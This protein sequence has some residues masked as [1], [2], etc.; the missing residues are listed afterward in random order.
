MNFKTDYTR[1]KNFCIVPNLTLNRLSPLAVWP[2]RYM[3]SLK[4]YKIRKKII[5]SKLT[6]TA[7]SNEVSC[8]DNNCVS[9][10][11]RFGFPCQE[12]KNKSV[13]KW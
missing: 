11:M 2:C 8:H 5:Y 6:V 10:S 13:K 7:K 9:Y 3:K 12:E 4:L 1:N